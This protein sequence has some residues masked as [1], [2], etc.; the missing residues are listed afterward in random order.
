MERGVRR[1]VGTRRRRQKQIQFIL[2][3]S[4]MDVRVISPFRVFVILVRY[5]N[6]D[7]DSQ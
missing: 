5:G 6:D 3:I 7:N 4:V 2:S 1:I